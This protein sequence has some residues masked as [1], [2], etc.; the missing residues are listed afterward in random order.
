MLARCAREPPSAGPILFDLLEGLTR[1][2]RAPP[3]DTPPRDL[4]RQRKE[5]H[6]IDQGQQPQEQPAGELQL[7]GG[8]GQCRQRIAWIFHFS[9]VEEFAPYNVY[10]PDT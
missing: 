1:E 10:L 8:C 5:G 3:E 4:T 9:G 6:A 2:H 7:V